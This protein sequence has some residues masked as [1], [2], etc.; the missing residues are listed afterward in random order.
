MKFAFFADDNG[1]Y[2]CGR[3]LDGIFTKLMQDT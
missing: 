1:L 2:S 3:V